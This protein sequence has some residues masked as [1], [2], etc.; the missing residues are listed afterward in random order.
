MATLTK[1]AKQDYVI[2]NTD[3]I[4]SP[5]LVI[6]RDLVEL[7]LNEMI[8]IAGSADRLR[9]HCKTHKTREIV[10]M[11]IELGITRHKCATLR[12][13][14]ML[15]E[16][17]V[18]DILLAYQVVGPNLA[19][20]VQ[21]VERFPASRFAC[22]VDDPQALQ[23]LSSAFAAAGQRIGVFLDVDPGMHRTGINTDESAL[24]LYEMICTT[25]AIESRGLHWYD[26]H[27]RQTDLQERKLAVA[28]DWEP[29][30]QFRNQILMAG[31]KVPGVVAAGTGSFSILAEVG[32]PN[33][34]LSPGTT[35]YFDAGYQAIFPDLNFRPAL[36]I[37][38]R[39]VSKR[40]SGYL[41]LDIGHKS[42]AADPP[43]G[44]RLSFPEIPDA[45]EVKHTEEHLVLQTGCD[46]DFELGDAIVA[47]PTHACPTSAAHDDATVISN[48]QVVGQWQVAARGRALKNG[49]ARQ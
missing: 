46:H 32:E 31:F 26:G 28:Q 4:F 9:P 30:T 17:G 25:D 24:E 38:T 2:E 19:P 20:W 35:T 7:N 40:R 23:M 29:F 45:V 3:D 13:A 12:E 47:L 49:V 33:L 34:E 42:C 44:S 16:L 18:E 21:L 8:R 10:Q 14:E 41:T 6:F 48:R 39:V 27:H 37:L 15:A 11:Q 5:G 1:T 43:N 36:G 22:L